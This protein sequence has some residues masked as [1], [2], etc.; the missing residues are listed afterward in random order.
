MEN[1]Q[2]N[3]ITD[4]NAP[5]SEAFRLQTEGVRK[6]GAD[7]NVQNKAGRS[8]GRLDK[9]KNKTLRN[10]YSSPNNI[11]MIKS[12]RMRWAGHVAQTRKVIN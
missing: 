2:K 8:N 3:T 10:L 12:R 1:F 11:T 6:Q 9:M 7:K 5:S 4:Y